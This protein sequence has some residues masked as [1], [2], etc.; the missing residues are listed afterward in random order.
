MALS[1]ILRLAVVVVLVAVIGLTGCG[2]DEDP[3]VTPPETTVASSPTTGAPRATT[4]TATAGRTVEYAY[5]GGQVEGGEGRVT[6]DLGEQVTIRVVSDV[7]EEVHVHTYDRKVDLQPDV[8]GEITFTADIP[9]VHEVELEGSHVRL[10]SLEV[11]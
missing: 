2:D 5:R 3:T 7:A 11:R 10:F 1:R 6:V 4:T 9:G 8:A